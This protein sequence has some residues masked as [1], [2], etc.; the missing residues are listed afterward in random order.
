MMSQVKPRKWVALIQHKNLEVQLISTDIPGIY[1]TDSIN[2]TMN[3]VVVTTY[4]HIREDM[5]EKRLYI[6]DIAARKDV[7]DL[8]HFEDRN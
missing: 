7:R 6:Y 8:G 5:E 4:N 3:G 1:S 2:I